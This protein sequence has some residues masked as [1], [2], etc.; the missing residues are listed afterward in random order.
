MTDQP[1][2]SETTLEVTIPGNVLSTNAD[3]I[4]AEVLGLMDSKF[5]KSGAWTHLKL[6]LTGAKI[7]DSV[8]LNLVVNFYKE[9]KKRG[10]TTTALL[11]SANIQRTFMFT[12]LDSYIQVI[13]V[14][15]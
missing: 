3:Q 8:G 7:I 11:S 13:L 10:A 1:N 14:A 6:D 9:A 15:K 5:M 12:R 4:K 2:S